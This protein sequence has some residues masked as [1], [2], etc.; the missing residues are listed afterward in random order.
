MKA[1]Y[2]RLIKQSQQLKNLHQLRA[3]IHERNYRETKNRELEIEKEVE[4]R[5][6][7]VEAL[8]TKKST[9]K[10]YASAAS[11]L[12]NP[13]KVKAATTYQFWLD[14]DL[15]KD[16]YYLSMEE[17]ELREAQQN[18]AEAKANW[19]KS[20]QRHDGYRK[21]LSKHQSGLLREKESIQEVDESDRSFGSMLDE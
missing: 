4:N 13:E 5:R 11:V 12:E 20:Q 6:R 8:K 9:T 3:D 14:Y 17:D 19:I 10:E 2:Q 7:L 1:N 21:Q 15:E 16:E 18:T